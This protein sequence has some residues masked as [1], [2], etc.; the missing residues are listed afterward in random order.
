MD[1]YSSVTDVADAVPDGGRASVKPATEVLP[2][3]RSAQ[4]DRAVLVRL[5][6]RVR[7]GL[8]EA[9]KPCGQREKGL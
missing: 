8:P 2:L 9:P 3:G 1:D 6:N 5:A 4:D 7:E